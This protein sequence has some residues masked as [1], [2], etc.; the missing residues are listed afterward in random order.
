MIE[1]NDQLSIEDLLQAWVNIS[2]RMF[3]KREKNKE[4]AE[5][6]KQIIDRLRTKGI[7]SIVIA[8]MDHESYTLEYN[9]YNNKR[10]KR[11]IIEK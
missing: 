7:N 8:G 4:T 10:I 1:I 2:Y 9:Q 5:T 6:R 11:I 3:F